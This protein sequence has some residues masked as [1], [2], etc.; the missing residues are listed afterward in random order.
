MAI[1]KLKVEIEEGVADNRNASGK[2]PE[3]SGGGEMHFHKIIYCNC[4][5]GQVLVN[6]TLEIS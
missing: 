5:S 1:V 4:D 3:G 6:F 2:K